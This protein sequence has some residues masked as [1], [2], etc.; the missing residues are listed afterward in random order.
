MNIS[1]LLA[2][3]VSFILSVLSVF[4]GAAMPGNTDYKTSA[5]KYTAAASTAF[6]S[7]G[8]DTPYC[9]VIPASAT[10]ADEKAAGILNDNI[11]KVTGKTLTVCREGDASA[12]AAA[13]AGSVICIGR[14][15]GEL[16]QVTA[17]RAGLG[18]DG[19]V[20]KRIGDS[21]YLTGSSLAGSVYAVYRFLEELGFHWYATDCFTVPEGDAL[22]IPQNLDICHTAAFAYRETCSLSATYDNTY[23]LANGLNG[24]ET[25]RGRTGVGG[26][27]T[28]INSL[29]HSLTNSIV[30][31]ST[32]FESHPEY[33]A[34]RTDSGKRQNTQLCLSNPDV[35]KT[36]ISDVLAVIADKIDRYPGETLI[37]SV[38]QNDNKQYCQCDKCTALADKY[39]GQSGLMIWFVNQIADAVRAAGYDNV[40]V[41][42]FAYTYTRTAPT[43]I[44]PRDNVCV[45]LCS[46]ECCFGHTLDD[47]D[48]SQNA[49]FMTDLK[50][51]RAIA[52][53][54]Y[55]WD[56]AADFH[57]LLATFPDF[58][59]IARDIQIFYENGANGVFEEGN[60]VAANCNGELA[61][62][63]SYLITQLL[64]D[65]YCDYDTLMND[66]MAAYYGAG[67]R[68]IREYKDIVCL[69]TC[70]FGTHI[71]PLEYIGNRSLLTLD[72]AS[73]KTVDKL[74]TDAKAAVT[75]LQL[76]H[77]Q[78]V[79]I[80]WRYWKACNKVEE[81]SR[82]QLPS[83]W[84][85]ANKDFYADL[86]KLG[87]HQLIEERAMVEDPDFTKSP[88]D[89]RNI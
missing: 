73:M 56:Y 59:V 76:E 83:V 49:A 80:S 53:H 55:I 21:V 1:G 20:I 84:I 69:N 7:A 15:A 34:Y 25:S 8:A 10:A 78:R 68:N 44:V 66:F 79:E 13:A 2:K 74:F 19:V 72:S 23:C 86:Q 52:K 9:I 30:S 57:Q 50:A 32:Y 45:R 31:A 40:L 67:W 14:T 48:C 51:W 62:L 54:L 26:N 16:E 27:V 24:T 60:D 65:P 42:T 6:V 77:V 12:S 22:T 11:A 58:D 61:E 29:A 17:A 43:G 41:D 75:G 37:V 81:F 35:L 88:S 71:G 70:R 85:Q 87:I 38:T 47:P 28:Y 39:G 89:W 82:L 4:T 64:W 36:V 46:I 33:F 5:E 3:I 18:V 63:R